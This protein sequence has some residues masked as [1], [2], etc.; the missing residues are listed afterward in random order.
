MDKNTDQNMYCV[1]ISTGHWIGPVSYPQMKN[2]KS[3]HERHVEEKASHQKQVNRVENQHAGR[4]HH[5]QK[6][7]L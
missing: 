5:K 6:H 4:Q 7:G 3:N 2:F 1:N